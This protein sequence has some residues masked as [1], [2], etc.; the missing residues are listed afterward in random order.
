M[1][2]ELAHEERVAV[3]ALVDS[4]RIGCSVQELGDLGDGE[5]L[6]G[7]ALDVAVAAELCDRGEQRC[8][9]RIGVAVR[10]DHEQP[11]PSGAAGHS[12]EEGQR[13]P[14]GEV[15]VVEH[16]HDRSRRGR[17]GQSRFDLLAVGAVP[18]TASENGSNG[19]SAWS[20][21]AP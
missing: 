19:T 3:G 12:G 7:D 21:Q 2:C 17:R 4:A 11:L 9:N 14:I 15:E 10:A 6:D 5:A 20:S 1:T 18:P 13:V 16:E 8:S